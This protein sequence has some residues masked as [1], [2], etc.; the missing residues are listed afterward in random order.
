MTV[1]QRRWHWR[2]WRIL[3]PLVAAGLAVALSAAAE[4][5]R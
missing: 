3:L 1:A 5:G 2:V 4:A